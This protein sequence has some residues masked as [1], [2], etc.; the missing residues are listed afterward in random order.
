MGSVAALP[1]GDRGT[2]G[3]AL[4]D[5]FMDCFVGMAVDIRG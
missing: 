4:A 2:R 5:L 3:V 1:V